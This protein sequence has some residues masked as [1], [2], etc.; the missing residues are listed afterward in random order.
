MQ[1]N[2][3]SQQPIR[4]PVSPLNAEDLI[5]KLLD[6]N[7]QLKGDDEQLRKIIE[8][9]NAV[10]D[11]LTNSMAFQQELIQQ[12]RDEIAILKGQKPKPKIPPSSLEGTKAKKKFHER[13]KKIPKPEKSIVFA[14]WVNNF[15]SSIKSLSWFCV[16]KIAHA[17]STLQIKGYGISRLAKSIVKK[18]KR[19]RSKPGQPNGKPRHK[20]KGNWKFTIRLIF[21]R[22]TSLNVLS[23]RD[24]S[25]ILFR[26]SFFSHIILYIVEGSGYYP[27]AAIL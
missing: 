10:I 11:R 17:N 9:N 6:D 16:S 1:D 21:I 24:T 12:L 5:R 22:Q 25:P 8:A 20:K 3:S 2:I 15:V 4:I 26:K 14:S 23:L 7:A 27:M 13:F 18:V 19:K